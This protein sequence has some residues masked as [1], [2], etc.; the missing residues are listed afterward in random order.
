MAKESRKL[1]ANNKKAFHDYFIEDTYEAGI[2]LHG[3]EVK[4]LRQGHCSIKESFV[5]IL[6]RFNSTL[7]N[8]QTSADEVEEG[9]GGISQS[10]QA[11]A[12]GGLLPETLKKCNRRNVPYVSVLITGAVAI[13]LTLTGSFA[14]LAAISVISRFSQYIPTCIAVP[15]LRRK[16]P[17]HSGYKVPLGMMF[18]VIAVLTSVWLLYHTE[19]YRLVAGLGAML[20]VAPL[21]LI[22]KKRK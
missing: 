13:L 22:M 20:L 14:E 5:H 11:L 2:V 17:E 6:K 3:T 15:V 16:N 8:I 9:A 19:V 10:S 12:E 7:T 1:I 21:Y 18:P 4:S